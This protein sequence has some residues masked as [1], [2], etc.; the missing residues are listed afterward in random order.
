LSVCAI[1]HRGAE[2]RDFFTPSIIATMLEHG[3]DLVVTFLLRHGRATGE[4]RPDHRASD[5]PARARWLSAG[6]RRGRRRLDM[7][8]FLPLIGLALFLVLACTTCSLRPI[9]R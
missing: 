9:D 6:T 3:A 4:D 5:A 8:R 1:P 7:L 2:N